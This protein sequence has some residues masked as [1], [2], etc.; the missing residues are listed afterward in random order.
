MLE[1]ERIST[2]LH[3]GD[4]LHGCKIYRG[5]EYETYAPG[6]DGQERAV[7]EKYPE[8]AV[9]TYFITGNHDYSFTKL[10]GMLVGEKLEKV[11]PHSQFIGTDAGTVDLKTEDGHVLKIGL[12][13]PDGGTAYAISYKSQKQAEALPGGTKPDILGIG[14]YHKAD[15]L[16]AFRNMHVFQ[17]GCFESQ[18][19]FMKRKGTPAHVGGWIIEAVMGERKHLV[20]RVKSE[21]IAFYEP[22]ER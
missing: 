4:V 14:H 1:Q 20:S 7:R 19:P 21:F 5:Q 9:K 13:H 16:P 3:A 18:T 11:I 17:V 15:H 8:T 12:L 10:V 2:C 6:Y 22:E